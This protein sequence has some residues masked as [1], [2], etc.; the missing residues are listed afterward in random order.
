M[1]TTLLILTSALLNSFIQT[2]AYWTKIHLRIEGPDKTLYEKT[3]YTTGHIVTTKS[4]GTHEC[5]GTNNGENAT[6]GATIISAIDDAVNIW[7]GTY[8]KKNRDYKITS[9]ENEPK[10]GDG[11][12]I[13]LV[14]Y[15][16]LNKGGCIYRVA[17]DDQVLVA[18]N[19]VNA[20]KF[21]KLEADKETIKV[22]ESVVFTVT[23]GANRDPVEGAAVSPKDAG[24]G[25]ITGKDGTATVG[26]DS[27]TPGVYEYKAEADEAIRSNKVVITV[28]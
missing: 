8:Q 26:F 21:L 1:R 3:M 10:Q 12:W 7:D 14:G 25:G 15:T 22:G 17:P 4:G 2:N 19:K 24:L 5:D 6:P 13:L 11:R 16:S 9:I 18:F 28:E 27:I 20:K 23:N